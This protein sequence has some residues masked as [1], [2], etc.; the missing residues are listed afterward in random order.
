MLRKIEY[1]IPA[2][3]S[4]IDEVL[5]KE[6]QSK[7]GIPAG[8]QSAASGFGTTL[9]QMG[10]MPT[11]AVYTDTDSNAD[12]DRPKLLKVLLE[13]IIHQESRF[14]AK[15]TMTSEP[16]KL[17]ETIINTNNFPREE[18]KDKLLE[19][20]LAFKLGIRTYKLKSK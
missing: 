17:L 6:Y 3:L 10:L 13:I 4:A 14:S 11:V 1:L 19:A 16:D 18:L 15:A 5:V 9:M 12:I 7:G 20:S 8:Y 2:A